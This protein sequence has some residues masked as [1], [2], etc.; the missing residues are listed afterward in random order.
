MPQT[1]CNKI[2]FASYRDTLVRAVQSMYSIV[3]FCIVFLFV[4]VL[5][6]LTAS[7]FGNHTFRAIGT[8]MN[9]R[10]YLYCLLLSFLAEHFSCSNN[11]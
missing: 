8:R 2:L 5:L 1:V 9:T 10:M 11:S 4:V 6:I 3:P 7:M